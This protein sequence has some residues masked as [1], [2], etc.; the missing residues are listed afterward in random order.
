MTDRNPDRR[1]HRSASHSELIGC[2]Y[3]RRSSRAGPAS[4]DRFCFW[5]K[6]ARR[7]AQARVLSFILCDR[8]RRPSPDARKD[9]KRGLPGAL[10][11]ELHRRG[12]RGA[13][14]FVS[15]VYW[16][17]V[18]L[19]LVPPELVSL[20]STTPVLVDAGE[21]AVIDVGE[22]TVNSFA[23][24]FPNETLVTVGFSKFSP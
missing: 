8:P 12:L 2:H 17:A 1:C 10:V 5:E 15:Y 13:A 16:S 7:V 11:D 24:T 6:Q 9:T 14:Y 18:V 19:A 23:A 4:G 3:G 22:V 20:T 21:M